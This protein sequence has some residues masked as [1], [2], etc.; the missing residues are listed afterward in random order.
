MTGRLYYG[1]CL[2]IMQAEMHADEVDLIYLDPP[3]NSN[4]QYNAIY[5]DETGRPLPA[6]IDA[7]CDMWTLD[8]EQERQIR[9]LPVLMR[10]Q[11]IPDETVEFCRLW[12]RALRNTQP[13]L[14]AYLAYMVP[15]LLQ[16]RV[17]LK[18]TGSIYLHCDPTASHYIKVMMD[19]IFGHQ[20]F[21]N[22]VIWKRTYAHGSARRWGPIHDVIL[23]Y[24][25]GG[26]PTWN[27]VHQA[28]DTEYIKKNFTN[29]DARGDYQSVTLDASGVRNGE[30]GEPW[31][32]IDPTSAG[33]HWAVPT[34]QTLP[35]WVA[36]PDG[37]ALM[38]VQERLDVLDD[39]GLIHWPAKE[40]GKPRL[41]FYL[42]DSPGSP[43]Q[44]I[45]TDIGPVSGDEDTG[46]DTQKPLALLRRIIEASSNPGDV[47]LDP[48]CGCATTLE[49]AQRLGREWIGID[50]AIH[51]VNR[52]SKNR[53]RDRLGLIEG[54]DFTISGV[55]LSVEAAL[56]LWTRDKYHFQKWVVEAVDGFVTTKRTADGGIDGRLYFAQSAAAT[57]LDSMVIEVKGGRNVGIADV[58]ALKCVL[59]ADDALMAG[60]IVLHPLGEKKTRNFRLAMAEAGVVDIAGVPYSRMQMLTVKQILAG[61]RFATPGAVGRGEAQPVL[62]MSGTQLECLAAEPVL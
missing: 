21:L 53:L 48:F 37:Y 29:N 46:Y 7:F 59:D 62:P 52:V 45:I 44:D 60:L 2:S 40:G 11:G 10:S 57:D 6:Q 56:D 4:R 28:Y 17:V 34:E 54:T 26:K 13:S 27:P 20:S 39:L 55:P 31:K 49:A 1:D 50:I 35:D 58:R 25:A 47:V 5:K 38:S 23:Y 3:F 9:Q 42:N 30:S 41:K 15:R 33:R 24:S 14:L 16:M 19:A 12:M 8:A 61:E 51:A 36:L 22:E 18:P 32:D 43:L